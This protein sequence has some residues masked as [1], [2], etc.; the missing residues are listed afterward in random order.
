MRYHKRSWV[1]MLAVMLAVGIATTACQKATI[2]IGAVISLTNAAGPSVDGEGVRDGLQLAIDEANAHGGVNGRK[3]ELILADAKSSDNEAKAAFER[4]EEARHPLFYV[5]TLSNPSLAL[6]PLAGQAQVPL[7]CLVSASPKITQGTDWAYRYWSSA[8]T[9]A[10]VYLSLLGKLGVKR[11]GVVYLNDEFGTSVFQLVGPEFTKSGGSIRGEPFGATETDHLQRISRL[12]DS[13]AILIVCQTPQMVPVLDQIRKSG[14]TGK[15]LANNSVANPT[16]TKLPQTQG[17]YSAVPIIFK[18]N[19]L[20]ARELMQKFATRYGRELNLGAAGGYDLI[21]LVGDLLED[22]EISR[23]NLKA[24][25]QQGFVHSGV[26]GELRLSPGQRDL[27]MP[28][29]PVQI[30]DGAIQYQ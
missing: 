20:Y 18:A 23:P 27:E 26:F 10:P 14:Y 30:V 7:F 13:D 24:R 9:Y 22:Q 28:A 4:I 21:K 11:L 29:Y 19:F 2:P 3:L 6:G 1:P 5:S 25:L 8:T 12:M 16:V 15:V 17:V